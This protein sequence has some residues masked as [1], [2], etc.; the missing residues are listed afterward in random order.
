[1]ANI[2]VWGVDVT[3]QELLKI[4]IDIV[5]FLSEVC[6]PGSE[7]VVH[8]VS[9][10]NCS[11]VTIGNPVSGRSIGDPLTD[12]AQELKEKAS[13][14]DSAY[15]SNYRG[16]SKKRDFLSSTY[17]IK[18]EGRLIGLLCINKDMTAVESANSALKRLLEN[19]NLNL[20]GESVYLENL[21]APM[22]S[23]VQ[24]RIAESIAKRGVNPSRLS[25]DEKVSIV[26]QLNEEGLLSVKGAVG[27]IAEQ[28]S[29][30]VPTV[31][32]YIKKEN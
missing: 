3:D 7:I 27:E 9:N 28:L 17:Y 18:N 23:I 20:A 26:H 4:Y 21:D 13:Y 12:L 15:V 19:F 10:P 14:T 32:R 31:Y 24:K 16:R 8:D 5:P 2:K 25:I 29:V 22:A 6:G 11:L 30:S 1:M